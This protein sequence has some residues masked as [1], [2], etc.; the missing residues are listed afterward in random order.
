MKVVSVSLVHLADDIFQ[1][2]RGYTCQAKP[3]LI[4]EG[5]T[6]HSQRT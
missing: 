6:T 1:M 5:A 2:A 4:G 3:E